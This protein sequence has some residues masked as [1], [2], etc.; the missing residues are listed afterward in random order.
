MQTRFTFRQL[1]YLVAV[2]QEGSISAA[3]QR[4]NVSSPSISAAISQLESELGI[5][6][7]VRQH[8][9]GLSLTTGG[10]RI[11]YEAKQI[12]A[13]AATLTDTANEITETVRGPISVGCLVTMAPLVSAAIRRS[14]EMAHPDAHVSLR[15]A[16]QQDLLAMLGRAEI[17]FAITYDLDIPNDI[18]FDGLV[19]LPPYVILAKDHPLAHQKSI[20]LPDIADDPMVLLDLPLSRDYFLGIFSR[21]GLTPNI[22]ERSTDLAVTR[23]LV[24]N[25]FGYSL[26]NIR[27]TTNFAPDGTELAFLPLEGE[28]RPMIVGLARKESMHTSSIMQ[29]FDMH[30]QA[31]AKNGTLPG[32]AP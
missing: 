28:H 11:F 10:Q 22:A 16:N 18:N 12:L 4:V 29:A 31:L 1:E 23:S 7:F 30:V 15:E 6:I 26:I 32:M 19:S 5:Q 9:Q 24:A 20:S 14:F 25:G 13:S 21:L 27:P 2:G 8:A 3:A 17:D